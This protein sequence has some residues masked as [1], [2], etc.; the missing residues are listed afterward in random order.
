MNSPHLAQLAGDAG[1]NDMIAAADEKFK[2]E[3]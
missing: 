3:K 1:K 2:V